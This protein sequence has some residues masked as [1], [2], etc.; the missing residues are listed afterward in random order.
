MKAFT[1]FAVLLSGGSLLLSGCAIPGLGGGPTTQIG[2][3]GVGQGGLF[4]HVSYPSEN[5]STTRYELTS[6]DFEIL[7][8]VT[9]RGSSMNILG[10]VAMGESGY[11]KALNQARAGGADELMNLRLDTD[12]TNILG[13]F[14]KSETVVT[15]TAIRWKKKP[16]PT[17][18][19]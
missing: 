17:A 10:I 8:P 4:T 18:K 16:K 2:P 9:G 3:S 6:D 5:T 15:G 12:F 7:G 1:C 19:K 14:K 11:E 13:L